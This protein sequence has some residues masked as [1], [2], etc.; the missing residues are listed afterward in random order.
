MAR[1]RNSKQTVIE[2]I[3]NNLRKSSAVF[4]VNL[5][6]LTVKQAS[7]LRKKCRAHNLLC[8]MAKKTLFRKVF[9]DANI[10]GIDFKNLEGEVAAAFSFA[11]EV[12]PAKV[13]ENF[14][15]EHIKFQV[16]LGLVLA[17]PKGV[18][19]LDPKAISTLSLLPSREELLGNL[20]GTLAHPLRGIVGV[21]GGP[22]RGF[23]TVIGGMSQK[24]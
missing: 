1:S 21:L 8:L 19:F 12:T 16:L 11:D 15:K 23:I 13:L 24:N 7:A 10:T 9:N 14:K 5:K 17:G 22:I 18:Q 4:F 3:Q 20:V 6:G 2:T